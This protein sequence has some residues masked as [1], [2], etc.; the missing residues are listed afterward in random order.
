MPDQDDGAVTP[1]DD[2]D[3]ADLRALAGGVGLE[4]VEWEVPPAGM[5][6]RIAAEAGVGDPA[7]GAPAA[8]VGAGLGDAPT[9]EPARPAPRTASAPGAVDLGA[10]RRDRRRTGARLLAAAAAVLV[11]VA[12]AVV[13]W[14]DDEGT[15][16][17][18][19]SLDRLADSGSGTAELVEVDGTVRL[20]LD[21]ED[22]AAAED[23]FLEVWVIDTEVSQ[24]V[25]L[26]PLRD[27]GLYDLP[28]G[29][30]P[31]SFPV[32]D[33]SREPLDGDPA[34]SG[35]SLLRGQLEF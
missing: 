3:L 19:A 12:G 23:G 21:T 13:L 15:V 30:D 34:H 27:D 24:L 25:S 4:P 31:E 11:V 35:D 9:S 14:P 22:I 18:A 20:R 5:W 29:L 33:V 10:A 28:D 8:D 6:E 26:G 1:P 32:V 17:A 7:A 16:L 2:R